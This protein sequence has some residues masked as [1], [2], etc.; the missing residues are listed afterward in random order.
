M[1]RGREAGHFCSLG[2]YSVPGWAPLV[3][4][5]HDFSSPDYIKNNPYAEWYLTT[6]RI[7][8]SATQRY[9][10]EHNGAGYDHYN[11][12]PTFNQEIQ[13]WN[14][15]TWATIFRDATHPVGGGTIHES[16]WALKIIRI[17]LEDCVRR[18]VPK[19]RPAD[20]SPETIPPT[21]LR[22]DRSGLVSV[23]PCQV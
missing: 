7:E 21:P 6:M 8:G 12:A 13:K 10:A 16:T 15:E 22:P 18:M 2:L 19:S 14:P 1:V 9:H 17:S 11:F 5:N 3:H 23:R 20:R 4:P